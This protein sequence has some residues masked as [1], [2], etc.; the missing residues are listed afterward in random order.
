MSIGWSLVWV[1]VSRH[2]LICN[3]ESVGE[4]GDVSPGHLIDPWSGCGIRHLRLI[5]HF[6][7]LPFIPSSP[8]HPHSW[9][10]HPSSDSFQ[11][12]PG[13]DD[14][15]KPPPAPNSPFSPILKSFF[16]TTVFHPKLLSPIQ[17]W[18][19]PLFQLFVILFHSW[20]KI[21][22]KLFPDFTFSL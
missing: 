20:T 14:I 18:F 17:F 21:R 19:F 5:L 1:L 9:L 7:I 3:G 12:F 6:T 16:C 8:S 15:P 2:E 10:L 13:Q 4:V 11:I 22:V